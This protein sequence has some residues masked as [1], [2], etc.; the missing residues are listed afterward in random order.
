MAEA[1]ERVA[2]DDVAEYFLYLGTGLSDDDSADNAEITEELLDSIIV[3]ISSDLVD[4]IWQ[5]EPFNLRL[6]TAVGNS[7][8][9]FHGK[10]NF[11]D[12]VE[13]EWFMV[14]LLIQITKAF[15]QLIAKIYDGDGEFLL[16][17]AAEYL[18]KWLEPDTCINRVFLHHGD[19][20]I[21]PIPSSPAD[22]AVLPTGSPSL[23]VALQTIK[24]HPDR[25]VASEKI[26]ECIRNRLKGYPR[27]IQE[28]YH[29]G[30]CYVPA[31]VAM[32]LQQK[33][34]LVAPAVQAF[35]FRDP[36]DLKACRRMKYFSAEDRV[37]ARVK[38]TKCLYGQLLQ[39]RFEPDKSSG[40]KLPS[41]SNPKYTAY[42]MGM[43]LAHGFEILC[44]KCGNQSSASS[45]TTTQDTAVNEV[46]WQRYLQSLKNKDYFRGELEGSKLYQQLLKSAKEFYKEVMVQS[47][48]VEGSEPGYQVMQILHSTKVDLE[49]LREEEKN[50]PPEDDNSWL[51]L[52]PDE[53]DRMLHE[54]TGSSPAMGANK[55]SQGS[56]PSPEVNFDPGSI[57]DSMKAFVDKVSSHEGAEFPGMAEDAK[58]MFSPD[59][60]FQSLEKMM[61]LEY[62]DTMGDDNEDDSDD[63]FNDE[64]S[65]NEANEEQEEEAKEVKELMDLMDEELEG[66]TIGNSFEKQPGQPDNDVTSSSDSDQNV[67][68][69]KGNDQ[70]VDVDLN[71]LKNLLESFSSQQG[72]AGPASNILQSMGITV[73][74]D[75]DALD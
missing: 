19:I 13:D 46:R 3:Q 65:D 17:E 4:Y 5:R 66:T 42:D 49:K 61:N 30:Y 55:P 25:T 27:K 28:N 35:Y 74:H 56:D 72:L 67:T 52:S 59:N 20:H 23:E 33:P 26:Q 39:Q 40:W 21:I 29:H 16:I 9:H 62:R 73:P 75:M 32:V 36:I 53:L 51:Y 45:S 24:Q 31:N 70:P 44:S 14:Y 68:S 1:L 34:A 69:K 47:D 63:G 43:K 41:S 7:P 15:P 57:T 58:I 22:I 38:F 18:P 2:A 12:N 54:A 10:T 71:L 64:D 8:S 6:V 60:F 50:L 11:G 48:D 37:M